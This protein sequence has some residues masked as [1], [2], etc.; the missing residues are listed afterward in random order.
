M[1]ATDALGNSSRE[2]V[3][4]VDFEVLEDTTRPGRPV[5]TLPGTADGGAP[6][7][8]WT[9]VEDD[10]GVTY[11]LEIASG[12]DPETGGDQGRFVIP[13]QV[14]DGIPD[15]AE[16]GTIQFTLPADRALQAGVYTLHVA[17]VDGVGN[18]GDFSTSEGLTVLDDITAPAPPVLLSPADG[19]SLT[20]DGTFTLVWENVADPSGV[21][22]E[23]QI[24]DGVDFS[25]GNLVIARS[26][27]TGTS[28]PVAGLPDFDYRWWVRAVDGRGNIGEFSETFTFRLDAT[29]PETKGLK[30]APFV[31]SRQEAEVDGTYRPTL[32]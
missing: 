31:I 3:A 10:N 26:G 27:L 11:L 22:F 7:L 24:S 20:G 5:L 14:F 30:V 9:R 2:F 23:L 28:F 4:P 16:G 25:A 29:A 12:V 1:K 13:V 18:T 17:A 19:A 32:V 6:T 21:T 8:E 15:V